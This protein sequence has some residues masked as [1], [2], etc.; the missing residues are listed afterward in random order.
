MYIV[1]HDHFKFDAKFKYSHYLVYPRYFFTTPTT[2]LPPAVSA[3]SLR[4]FAIRSSGTA[5]GRPRGVVVNVDSDQA[6]IWPLDLSVIKRFLPDKLH[7]MSVL[8][9]NRPIART[10]MLN[11]RCHCRRSRGCRR[12][13]SLSS[14]LRLR[15]CRRRSVPNR[16][17]AS[18]FALR[19][20]P[21]VG[22]VAW[23]LT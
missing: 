11:R 1:I 10:N 3:Q 6:F 8:S 15:G 7:K 16:S 22:Y 23:S 12:R 9:G 14:S 18:Q 13:P 20:P 19:A 4:C 17:G 5:A 21:P 2:W